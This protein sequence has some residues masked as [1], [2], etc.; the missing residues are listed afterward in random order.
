MAKSAE[1]G[2]KQFFLKLPKTSP[3][4][5]YASP[6]YGPGGRLSDTYTGLV[7]PPLLLIWKV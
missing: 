2:E 5:E 4:H 6:Q 3:G 1:G 7:D